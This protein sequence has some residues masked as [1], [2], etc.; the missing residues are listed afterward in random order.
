M[1]S[2]HAITAHRGIEF[3]RLLILK[4]AVVL[5]KWTRSHTGTTGITHSVFF[6][7]AP[8][9]SQSH[10]IGTPTNAHT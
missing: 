6:S 8:C 9:T 10:L 4:L 7:V 1:V 2:L 5:G 3:I